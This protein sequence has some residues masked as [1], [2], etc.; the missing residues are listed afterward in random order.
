M[1]KICM[2]DLDGRKEGHCFNEIG[3]KDTK[4]HIEV[5]VWC[6]ESFVGLYFLND[7]SRERD[8]FLTSLP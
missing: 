5:I 2:F 4:M 8:F 7:L 3:P 1:K 6:Q